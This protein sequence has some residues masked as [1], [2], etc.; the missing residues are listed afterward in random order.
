MNGHGVT[1]NLFLTFAVTT[2][3]ASKSG[4]ED[5]S[6]DAKDVKDRR[7]SIFWAINSGILPNSEQ[8]SPRMQRGREGWC[9]FH[10]GSRS[11]VIKFIVISRKRYHTQVRMVT[12]IMA[13]IRLVIPSRLQ[14]AAGMTDQNDA[15]V[16]DDILK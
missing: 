7:P 3:F 15:C 5:P 1:L 4:Y 10:M 9:K 6:I 2:L 14:T 11:L 12:R 16:F 8:P 13:S